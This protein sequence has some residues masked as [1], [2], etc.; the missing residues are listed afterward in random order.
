[1]KEYIIW[2]NDDLDMLDQIKADILEDNPDLTD[3]QAAQLAYEIRDEYLVDEKANLNIDVGTEI[4][5]IGK[6][7]LWD[8]NRMGYKLP[9]WKN[10][11]DC[12]QGT[13][14][15]YVAWFV[16]DLGD[17]RC[18]DCHHDGTNLYTYRA[19]KFGI[20]ETQKENFLEKVYRGKATRADITRYTRKIGTY[21][22]DVYGWKVRR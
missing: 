13:C 1:M 17:L 11:A 8:G 5:V 9:R 20:S 14:G 2:S 15:D 21:V 22:A 10:I 18:R 6:L 4:V 12:F 7:G 3:E 19:W 16:D